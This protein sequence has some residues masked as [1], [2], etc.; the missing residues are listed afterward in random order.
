MEFAL[1][2]A[3]TFEMGSPANEPE[4]EKNEMQ[5]R[6]TL[7]RRF[8]MGVCEATQEQFAHVMGFNPSTVKG[9]L[10]LPVETV[11][12]FDAILFCNR[13]SEKDRL[14]AAYEISNIKKNG[15]HV[16]GAEVS[17]ILSSTG[18]RLPTEAEWE[19]ACR[20]GTTTA[21]IFGNT[22]TPE[23]ANFDGLTPY[24]EGA[25]GEYRNRTIEVDALL[26]NRF[27]LYHMSG[28]VFEW[29]WDYYALYPPGP[30]T[31]PTGPDH[32]T[33]RIRRGGS[34]KSPGHHMRSAMRH[35]VPPHVPFFHIGFRVVRGAS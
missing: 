2:P 23:D 28:N 20:A 30:A 15:D 19:F 5:H 8:Y 1:I 33:D 32:G 11:S 3:G 24:N 27:G 22:I 10:R 4:R 34:Y 25:K 18:Y 21:F 26:P 29:C 31:D 13:L 35:G 6:V 14:P 16:V 12:W 17:Q 9:S 7:T